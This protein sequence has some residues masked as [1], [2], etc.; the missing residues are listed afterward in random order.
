MA[1]FET[2]LA[3]DSSGGACS[4]ALWRRDTVVARPPSGD[5]ARP[6]RGLDAH[7]RRDH[8]R[9]RGDASCAHRCRRDRRTRCIHGHPHRSGSG[10]RNRAGGQHS[11]R[12]GHDLCRSR[13]GGLRSGACRPQASGP[14]GLEA[15]RRLRSGVYLGAR[16][17]RIAGDPVAGCDPASLGFRFIRSCRRWYRRRPSLSRRRQSRRRLF[18]GR[19]PG[20]RSLGGASWRHDRS[21]SGRVC[22]QPP[23]YLRAPEVRSSPAA[24]TN[25]GASNR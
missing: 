20:G 7:A 4:A 18:G 16:G 10:P 8:G 17:G 12:G 5:D 25:V 19:W 6:C 22:R 11:G 21:S 24:A 2:I 14:P 3:L 9:G 23:L 1:A 13:R 15:R